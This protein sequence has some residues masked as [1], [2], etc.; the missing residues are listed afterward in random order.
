MASLQVLGPHFALVRLDLVLEVKT[1]KRQA[2]IKIAAVVL[3]F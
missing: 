3:T 1:E 2:F